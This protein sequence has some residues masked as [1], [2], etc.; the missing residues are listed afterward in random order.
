M[1]KNGRIQIEGASVIYPYKEKA[2]AFVTED[3]IPFENA[4]VGITNP[5]QGYSICRQ[6]ST[7]CLFEYVIS[8]V[9]YVKLENRWVKVS[10]GDF[11]ILPSDGDH[12]Y[13]SD[14]ADPW[15][16]I[17][18]N[19]KSKYMKTLLEGYGINGGVYRVDG[20]E[21]LFLELYRLAD[22]KENT[23]NIAFTIADLL[24]KIVR[25]AVNETRGD[26]NDEYGMKK[27]IAENLFNKMTLDDLAASMHMSKSN[28]IRAFK[29]S[30]GVTPYEYLMELRIET[31]KTLLCDT[32][33][34]IKEIAEKLVFFDDNYFSAQFLRRVGMRPG[35]YRKNKGKVPSV[36]DK[37]GAG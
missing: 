7:I 26:E 27:Y 10:A 20:A 12:E 3:G 1:S 34:S 23:K 9:G 4:I 36:I 5:M 35:A 29:R 15:K 8:G 13:R 14:N 16:K 17:W 19:Y 24:Y 11:Y 25:L 22:L 21:E 32:T 2:H 6:N 31:A 18:I 30:C 37:Q 33:L 28:V